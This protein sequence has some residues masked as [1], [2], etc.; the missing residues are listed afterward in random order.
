MKYVVEI[1]EHLVRNVIVEAESEY[2]AE[3]KAQKAYSN[4]EVVLDYRD[5]CDNKIICLREAV[6]DDDY[7][8]VGIDN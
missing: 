2:E 8:E 4:E 1:T 6:D 5:Y 7:A 3:E